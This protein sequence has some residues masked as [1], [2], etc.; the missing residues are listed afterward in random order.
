MTRVCLYP[1]DADSGIELTDAKVSCVNGP[2]R[3][4]RS[5]GGILS[6]DGVVNAD[7][8]NDEYPLELNNHRGSI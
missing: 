8:E 4:C 3:D 5:R 1:F 7:D 2:D 6:D